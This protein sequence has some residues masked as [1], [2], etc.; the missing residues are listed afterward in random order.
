[1]TDNTIEITFNVEENIIIKNTEILGNNVISTAEL[2][3][4]VNDLKNKPQNLLQQT[5]HINLLQKQ[6]H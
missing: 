4:F 3:P 1:M 6:K 5:N 2:L